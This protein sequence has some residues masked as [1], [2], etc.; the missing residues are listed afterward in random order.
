METKSEAGPERSI[1]YLRLSLT[2]RC[3]LNCIYCTPLEKG[4]C[5]SHDEVLRYEE[6]IAVVASFVRAGVKRLRL[7]GGEPLIKKDVLSLVR[8]LKSVEGLEELSMT[9]NGTLL[10]LYAAQLKDAGLDRI[11]ISLDTLKKDRFFSITGK[12]LFKQVWQGVLASLESG[13]NPVKL[14]VVVMQGVNDD[15]I[16]DFARL[17]LENPIC[18][19]FI[20]FFHTNPRSKKLIN[21][22][23]SSEMVKEEIQDKL[24]ELKPVSGV[25]GRGPAKYYKLER[26][27]GTIGFINGTTGNFCSSC[28]RLRID[29]AGRIFPCLFSGPVLDLRPLLRPNLNNHKLFSEIKEIFMIKSQYNKNKIP[30]PKIEMSSLGG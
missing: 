2:D 23:V 25:I 1:D 11:N 21:S 7:T 8:M 16:A 3:N 6:I 14:N 26:A 10:S 12:D 4:Q 17:T 30:D 18:V 29:C 28:T 19:R 22:L 20:E 15:E 13:F 27:L 9:T 5:L 24:G